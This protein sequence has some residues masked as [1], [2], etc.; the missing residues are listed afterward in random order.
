MRSGALPLSGIV[1]ASSRLSLS[2]SLSS[3]R[4]RR[5]SD[6]SPVARIYEDCCNRKHVID[7]ITIEVPHKNL[8]VFAA[9]RSPPQSLRERGQA[10]A[11]A[12]EIIVDEVLAP[13]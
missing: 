7:A 4:S 12:D 13:A 2:F 3:S 9:L 11:H 10:R 8:V 5:A 1:S 6:I